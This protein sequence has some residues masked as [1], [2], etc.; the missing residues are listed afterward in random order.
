MVSV[1]YSFTNIQTISN[2]R[3]TNKSIQE[4][5][6]RISS[7]LKVSNSRDNPVAWAAAQSLRSEV[8]SQD[9]LTA[10]ISKALGKAEGS[11]GIMD[12]ITDILGKIKETVQLGSNVSA[13]FGALNATIDSYKTQIKNLVSSATINGDNWLNA[14]GASE[15]VAVAMNGSSAVNASFTTQAVYDS[16]GAANAKGFL[17]TVLDAAVLTNANYATQSTA[18]DTAASSSSA[19]AVGLSGFAESLSTQKD[20][21]ATIQGIRLQAIS[22]LVD[23]NLEEESAR[24][25]ALQ[26]KQQLAYQALSIGNSSTQNILRLFQ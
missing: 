10:N 25:N 2:L 22:D 12:K 21:Q 6:N 26:V 16:A 4:T 17:E 1:N 14:V 24:V 8:K 3:I 7:G 15:T 18:V 13:D 23:A 19:Y 9:G 5:Q 20:V 11:A